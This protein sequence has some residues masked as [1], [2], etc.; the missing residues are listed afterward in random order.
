MGNEL[1]ASS[2][3]RKCQWDKEMRGFSDREGRGTADH[4]IQL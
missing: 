1:N 3:F 4:V 2:S